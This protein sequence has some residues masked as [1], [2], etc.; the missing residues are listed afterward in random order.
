MA[1]IN[2]IVPAYNE[3]ERLSETL[4]AFSATF[5][6]Q[7]PFS[8]AHDIY[9]YIVNDGSKDDTAALAAELLQKLGISG[10]LLSYEINQGKGY[11]VRYG[12]LNSRPADYYYLAD[13]DLSSPWQ[14]LEN[15]YAAGQEQRAD[16]IIGSRARPESK[17]DT[18][19]SR[20]ISG[21]VSNLLIKL[22]LGL[23]ISDTQCGYKLFSSKCLPAFQKQTLMRWGFDFEILYI[24]EKVLHLKTLEVGITWKNKDGSK[25]K[26]KDYF[27][28]FNELMT[29][30]RNNYN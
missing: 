21:R 11:A 16:C 13:A 25:V 7:S 27:R 17:V 18:A 4:K 1:K 6:S 19:A 30:R 15:L 24:L 5:N 3:G 28:T 20:L 23:T 2:V 26:F 9:L 14:T 10:E 22:F 8:N 29:V 12:M